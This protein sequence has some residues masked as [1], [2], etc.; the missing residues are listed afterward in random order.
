MWQV[1]KVVFKANLRSPSMIIGVLACALLAAATAA[2]PVP[3]EE[4]ASEVGV[5]AHLFFLTVFLCF[6]GAL[7]AS[8]TIARD[9]VTARLTLLST[10]PLRAVGLIVGTWLGVVAFLSV[11][12]LVS[13]VF[14]FIA[15]PRPEKAPRRLLPPRTACVPGGY[16]SLRHAL[17]VLP[18]GLPHAG[19]AEAACCLEAGGARRRRTWLDETE[20]QQVFLFE[21]D[22]PT[23][24]LWITAVVSRVL[25][26]PIIVSVKTERGVTTRQVVLRDEAP[27]ELTFPP[28]SGPVTVTVTLTPWSAPVGFRMEPDE[29]GLPEKSVMLVV[30]RSPYVLQYLLGVAAALFKAAALAAAGVFCASFLSPAISSL[31]AVFLFFL[32][33]VS[34]YVVHMLAVVRVPHLH[35]GHVV[36]PSSALK[37][38]YLLVDW[39][40][41]AVPALGRYPAETFLTGGRALTGGFFLGLLVYLLPYL[42]GFLGLAVALYLRPPHEVTLSEQAR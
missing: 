25:K 2:I 15:L 30:G 31:L 6:L 20:P 42:V 19:L 3:V 22:S 21:P 4:A 5:E 10:R 36:A 12:A 13:F 27:L 28:A 39:V 38:V 35:H 41:R 26:T 37:F 9:R 1:A 24:R 23:G 8:S 16:V 40:C 7:L 14:G 18:C 29:S 33:A 32:S 17:S 34:R 11:L